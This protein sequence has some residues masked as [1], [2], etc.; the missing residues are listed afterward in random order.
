[1]KR[2]CN[3]ITYS[4][5]QHRCFDIL[6]GIIVSA[7]RHMP[8]VEHI[9]VK[10]AKIHNKHMRSMKCDKSRSTLLFILGHFS[11]MKIASLNRSRFALLSL[12]ITYTQKSR[13]TNLKKRSSFKKSAPKWTIKWNVKNCLIWSFEWLK[14]RHSKCSTLYKFLF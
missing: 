2:A 3:N 13:M 6:K 11:W 14:H 7:W 10:F 4:I 9:Y 1:M 12:A 8:T 5:C